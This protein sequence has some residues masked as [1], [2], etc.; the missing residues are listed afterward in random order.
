VERQN[1][2]CGDEVQKDGAFIVIGFDTEFK[3]PD[4]PM[5]ADGVHRP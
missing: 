3:T 5:T 4:S 1:F 2:Y